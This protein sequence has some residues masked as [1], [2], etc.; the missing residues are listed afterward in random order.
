ME[1]YFRL[2]EGGWPWR[3]AA[4]IAWAS[5]PKDGRQPKTQKELA[6]EH[7]GLSDDRVISTWRSKNEAILDMIAFLQAAPL[8]E[9]R[10]DQFRALAE[11]A[12]K[13]GQDYK[14]FNH[15]KLA[16]EMRGDYVPKSELEA[17]L[18]GK[19]ESSDA[20]EISREELERRARMADDEPDKGKA[21]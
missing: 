9:H 14:Y 18:R 15:L 17:M 11:G 5:S 1:D 7:L 4:Y 13:A 2:L 16:M 6:R 20:S 3:Q 21:E 19:A 10:S 8:W 12:N